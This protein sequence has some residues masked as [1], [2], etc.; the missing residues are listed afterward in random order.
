MGAAV[1]SANGANQCQT[2]CSFSS[3]LCALTHILSRE[4]FGCFCW[5]THLKRT[6]HSLL[7]QLVASRL[8]D[9]GVIFVELCVHAKRYR[10]V[11]STFPGLIAALRN[12]R[13]IYAFTHVQAGIARRMCLFA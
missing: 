12:C 4:K 9:Q 10:T 5:A 8:S 2:T 3:A 13:I 7:C 1:L 6:S 11:A